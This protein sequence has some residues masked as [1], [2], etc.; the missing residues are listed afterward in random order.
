MLFFAFTAFSLECIVDIIKRCSTTEPIFSSIE[1][2][3]RMHNHNSNQF[4]ELN[5]FASVAPIHS[6]DWNW[7]YF[8]CSQCM[9]SNACF[10]EDIKWAC[11]CEY[12]FDAY[13]THIYHYFYSICELL[14]YWMASSI[15]KTFQTPLENEDE[16][17]SRQIIRNG[18]VNL[19]LHFWNH[20]KPRGFSDDDNFC[21][22]GVWIWHQQ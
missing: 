8:T 21:T 16:R 22:L 6:I 5:F 20:F 3:V 12:T 18:E 11:Y 2:I 19:I 7:S 14:G 4:S 13:F 10:L 1:F 15:D 17:I 9:I